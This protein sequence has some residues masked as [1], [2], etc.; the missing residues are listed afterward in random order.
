MDTAKKL[1]IFYKINTITQIL[2]HLIE[3]ISTESSQDP[4]KY[5]KDIM[6]AEQK[7]L[8]KFDTT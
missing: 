8:K 1:I 7:E 3:Y 4:L 6:M 5:F 2:I